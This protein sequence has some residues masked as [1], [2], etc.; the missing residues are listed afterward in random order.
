LQESGNDL[1]I[2]YQQ[3][4]TAAASSLTINNW[5]TS[6]NKVNQFAF[7]DGNY[8]INNQHFVKIT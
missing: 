7:A 6:G 3:A 5:Y 1:V 8:T 2:D 4:G